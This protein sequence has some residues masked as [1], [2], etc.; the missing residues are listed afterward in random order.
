MEYYIFLHLT[1]F[2]QNS[3]CKMLHVVHSCLVTQWATLCHPMGCSLPGSSVRG[4]LQE[5]IL[6]WVAIP[7]PRGSSWSPGVDPSLLHCQGDSLPLSL[8]GSPL[9]VHVLPVFSLSEV[10]PCI[11]RSAMDWKFMS[12]KIYM[13]RPW[14]IMG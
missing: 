9:P 3:S 8:L 10:F 2:S 14:L 7:F 1:S 5:R 6:E 13:L 4:I 11:N 12:F